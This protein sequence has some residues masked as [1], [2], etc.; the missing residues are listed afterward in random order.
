[1]RPN[2]L[3]REKQLMPISGS[4]KKPVIMPIMKKLAVGLT[5]LLLVIAVGTP[6]QASIN[7]SCSKIGAISGTQKKPLVCKTVKGKRIWVSQVAAP[8]KRT[9]GPLSRTTSGTYLGSSIGI[10]VYW[11]FPYDAGSSPITGYRLEYM[12]VNTPWT[13]IADLPPNQYSLNVNDANPANNSFR[14]RVAATNAHGIGVFSESDWILYGFSTTN[15]NVAT[16]TTVVSSQPVATTTTTTI[17]RTTT[18]T[19]YVTNSRTQAVKSASDYLRFMA[20]SRSGLIKQLQYE[21]FSLEDATYGV[22]AQN[23]DWNTQAAKSA[24]SYLKTMSFSRAGL[25]SQLLYEGFTQ[26]QAEY[27]VN[28]VGL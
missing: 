11:G 25:I 14:F 17:A 23:A 22:D 18:T 15:S 5:V 12:M 6:A 20:F 7:K 16:S 26:S 2:I 3:S 27:G 9:P 4:P 13:F 8:V 10:S 19:T 28:A 21:K 24:T 1:M